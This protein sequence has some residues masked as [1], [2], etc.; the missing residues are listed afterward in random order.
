MSRVW[1]SPRTRRAAFWL[2]TAALMTATHT[3]NA[4][5][6]Y[7][8]FVWKDK[9]E[10]LGAYGLWTLLLLWSGL[11]GDRPF[12]TLAI[13]AVACAALLGVI[14]ELFQLIPALKRVADP[15][16]AAAD[17]AGSVCAVCAIWVARRLRKS[18]R[19]ED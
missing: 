4:A 17:V 12:R 13:R 7:I 19:D 11:L 15:W 10:H 8:S 16:D 5:I 9:L 2:Y 3:P 6:P 1:E 18:R 14:D